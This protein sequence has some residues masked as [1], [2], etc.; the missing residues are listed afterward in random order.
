VGNEE[1]LKKTRS[2]KE[3]K[4]R[5]GIKEGQI[6]FGGENLRAQLG[7]RKR[8]SVLGKKFGRNCVPTGIDRGRF[9]WH[10]VGG[11]GQV[12]RG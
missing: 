9:G 3:P 5:G 2:D 6:K 8:S 1:E 7:L 11:G 4:K 10:G 12:G